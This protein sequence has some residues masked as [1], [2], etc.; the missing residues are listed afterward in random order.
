MY[1]LRRER[2]PSRVSLPRQPFGPVRVSRSGWLETR[3]R[4]FYFAAHLDVRCCAC[5]CNKLSW[6]VVGPVPRDISVSENFDLGIRQET[7]T[8]LC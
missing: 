1:S 5:A 3:E 4:L 7:P 6:N 8:V 2:R